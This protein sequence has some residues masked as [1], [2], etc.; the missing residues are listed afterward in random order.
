VCKLCGVVA[1]TN[2]I[3]Q[4]NEKRNFCSENGGDNAQQRVNG[5]HFDP[6]DST[7]MNTNIIGN[8]KLANN[9]FSTISTADKNKKE[10]WRQIDCVSD[11]LHIHDAHFKK[12]M[13]E[14][15]HR[16]ETEGVLRG[17]PK[18]AKA[19]VIIFMT[20]R[21]MSR[22]L[23]IEDILRYIRTT[24]KEVSHVYKALQKSGVF[25]NLDTRLKSS[26]LVEKA[27]KQLQL[28]YK[29]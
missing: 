11:A 8:D 7:S 4:T 27:C 1:E 14:I 13:R 24:K 12:K 3:D 15:L 19:A 2:I 18:N 21:N 9:F 5:G 23:P 25:P 26:N 20:A 10:I 16:I 17:R 29:I 6:L 22:A 28:G